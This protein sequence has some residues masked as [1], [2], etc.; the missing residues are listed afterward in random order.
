MRP[1]PRLDGGGRVRRNSI[2]GSGASASESEDDSRRSNTI[3]SNHVR[4]DSICSIQSLKDTG[5]IG[6]IAKLNL[7]QKRRMVV[8]ESARKLAEARREFLLKHENKSPDKSKLTMYDLIY[9]NPTSNPMK[10]K[11]V[12]IKSSSRKISVC[13]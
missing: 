4:N 5:N 13:S 12:T 11:P 3:V 9:Y 6:N 7:G 1:T 2:Q 8:S 10:P